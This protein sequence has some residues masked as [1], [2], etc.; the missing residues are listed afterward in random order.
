M[1]P[2]H[3]P[4]PPLR[5]PAG[6]GADGG[7]HS[8]LG[9]VL[10]CLFVHQASSTLVL[11]ILPSL[12]AE[13]TGTGRAEAAGWG[14]LLLLAYAASQFLFAPLIGALSDRFG[15]RPV[16]LLSLAGLAGDHVLMALAPSVG[17]LLAG[18][19]L[20]GITGACLATAM[21]CAAD[22][23]APADRTRVFGRLHG[24]A[25]FGLMV[26]PLAGGLLSGVEPRLAFWVAGAAALLATAYGA[27]A[28]VET[29]PPE[30][31]RPF[32]PRRA[33][34]V[35]ALRGLS[36]EEGVGRLL[37][38]MGLNVLAIQAVIATLPYVAIAKYG[39]GETSVGV[40]LALIGG[41][42]IL[43][44][45]L[46][47]PR[48]KAAL[49][50][51]RCVLASFALYGLSLA[52]LSLAPNGAAFSFALVPYAAA[53]FGAPA[54]QSLLSG[55]LPPGRQGQLQGGVAALMSGASMVG[56]LVMTGLFTAFAAPDAAVAFPGA[57]LLFGAGLSL[58]ALLVARR[59]LPAIGASTVAPRDA[60]EAA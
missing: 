35:G 40:A 23:T 27:V 16:M 47:V 11:P 3:S 13:V 50:D 44:Q 52:L 37:L 51:G 25:G 6:E 34:P 55:R 24:V 54:M 29:L 32:D 58:A 20:A 53:C 45:T 1:T 17:W 7:G 30:K 39:W 21:A 18:R 15:R 9:F 22:V 56:P 57:P 19:F 49:G 46:A 48:L 2:D 42:A 31:R 38:A 5:P 33:N 41:V 28:L 43:V 36:A 8:P 60:S 26:G 4:N 12:I 10:V 14:G 59:A